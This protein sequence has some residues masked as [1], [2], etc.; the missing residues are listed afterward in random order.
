[1]YTVARF[2]WLILHYIDLIIS[3]ALDLNQRTKKYAN[4]TS[5]AD[6]SATLEDT[7]GCRYNQLYYTNFHII[8]VW[9]IDINLKTM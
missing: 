7:A 8:Y 9:L 5:V 3:Q 2:W 4:H 6:I 1:M